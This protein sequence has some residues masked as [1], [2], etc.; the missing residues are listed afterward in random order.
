MGT[1]MIIYYKQ[2]SEGYED[3]GRF[4]IMQKVGMSRSEV[5][6]AIRISADPPAPAAVR[7]GQYQIVR[8]LHCGN[9]S[10]LCAGLW[11]DL[12][13]DSQILL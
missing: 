8:G 13:H 6:G 9:G 5:K 2:I 11:T 10:G 3:Q 1:A 4:Q 7:N 12:L